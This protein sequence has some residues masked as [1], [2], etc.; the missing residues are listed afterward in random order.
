MGG[1]RSFPCL[2]DD[3]RHS[4]SVDD[5]NSVRPSQLKA[6]FKKIEITWFDEHGVEVSASTGVKSG[7][8]ATRIYVNARKN[9]TLDDARTENTGRY[10]CVA[11]ATVANDSKITVVNVLRINGQPYQLSK[12]K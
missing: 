12:I 11:T 5:A 10:M 2:P 7:A 3:V 4:S 8:T 6:N 1:S 9:L